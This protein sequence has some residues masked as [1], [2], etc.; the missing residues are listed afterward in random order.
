MKGRGAAEAARAPELA[1]VG[2]VTRWAIS[3]LLC[4][5]LVTA[6]YLAISSLVNASVV[7]GGIGDCGAVQASV[8]SRLYGVPV[9]VLGF[10]TYVV[11]A[12]ALVGVVKLRGEGSYLALLG[13]VAVAIAGMLFSLYLTY[14]E[15]FIIRAICPWCLA[16]AFAITAIAFLS[17]DELWRIAL[18]QEPA[19]SR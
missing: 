8:Y 14:V 7:C 15:L 1:P 16:S 17:V 2:R 9:S 19:G 12:G 13:L 5:G 11:L 6:G 3:G 10:G 18:G 4:L